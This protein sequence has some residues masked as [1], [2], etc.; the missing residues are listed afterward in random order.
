MGPQGKESGFA[1]RIYAKRGS[2]AEKQ[3]K[4]TDGAAQYKIRG[5]AHKSEGFTKGA[6]V[7]D[8]IEKAD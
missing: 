8:S 2:R 5:T 1:C 6:L 3:L 7:V 4:K